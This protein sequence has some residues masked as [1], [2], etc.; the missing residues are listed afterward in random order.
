M[1]ASHPSLPPERANFDPILKL[2]NSKASNDE[3]NPTLRAALRSVAT[4]RQYPHR[5]CFHAG[6]VIHSRCFFC[7]HTTVTQQQHV[8]TML[9]LD[10]KGLTDSDRANHPAT[11]TALTDHPQHAAA[12]AA[13]QPQHETATGEQIQAAPV[14]TL[15][16]RNYVCPSLRA[17]RSKHAPPA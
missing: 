10:R 16:H 9:Q 2:R 7:L 15:A 12:T 17:E 6:W 13:E 11:A 1:A 14:G 3:W 8:A 4:G 5:G